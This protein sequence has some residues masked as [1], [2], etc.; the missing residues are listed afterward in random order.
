MLL[1]TLMMT[2]DLPTIISN[3]LDSEF[4]LSIAIPNN[5]CV[6]LHKLLEKNKIRLDTIVSRFLHSQKS[7]ISLLLVHSWLDP[8]L[9]L[10]IAFKLS[11]L[12]NR[13]KIIF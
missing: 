3:R 12:D 7:A 4:N 1:S 10:L 5:D 13:S 11:P 8:K 9:H 6:I 2:F